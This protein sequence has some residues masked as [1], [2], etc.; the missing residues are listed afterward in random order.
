MMFEDFSKI[1]REIQVLLEPD[2]NNGY[3]TLRPMD[4]YENISLNSS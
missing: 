3:F 1:F 2:N 4:I